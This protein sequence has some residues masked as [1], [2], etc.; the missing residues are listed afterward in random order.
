M[1]KRKKTE[2][3]KNGQIYVDIKSHVIALSV[4]RLGTL[5]LPEGTDKEKCWVLFAG[6][7]LVC[8]VARGKN[9]GN[10]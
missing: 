2:A 7:L 9:R 1:E 5:M 8:I 10:G 4:W 3:D 6:R